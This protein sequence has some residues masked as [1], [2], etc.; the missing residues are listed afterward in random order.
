MCI[1]RVIRSAFIAALFGIALPIATPARAAVE[2]GVLS[3]RSLEAMSYVIVSNQPFECIFTPSAGG[4]VQHY[5]AAIHRDT[6]KLS[7]VRTDQSD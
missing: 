7:T 3:C 1:K 2:V 4:P 5:Q 6:A